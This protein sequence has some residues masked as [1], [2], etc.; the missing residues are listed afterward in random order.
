MNGRSLTRLYSN[1][2]GW[3]SHRKIVVFESDDWGSIRMPDR[4]TFDL[5]LAN[6][7][8][9]DKCPYNKYDCLAS[10]SDLTTVFEVLG[11]FSDYSGNPPVL[12]A[13]CVV[14]NPDFE[15]IR[16]SDFKE[17]HY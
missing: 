12:T 15:R 8:R 14:V 6:G 13:N 9:V 5:L 16:N 17:Y 1:L 4:A 3:H 7:I 2:R 10:E 11:S